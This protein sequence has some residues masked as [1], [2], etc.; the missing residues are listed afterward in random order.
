MYLVKLQILLEEFHLDC[1]PVAY[2]DRDY[3]HEVSL[4]PLRYAIV[5]KDKKYV[6]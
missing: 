5:D 2:Q 1:V 3:Y 6:I 4:Y